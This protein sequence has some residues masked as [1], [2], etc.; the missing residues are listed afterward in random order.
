MQDDFGLGTDT[1]AA[2]GLEG[3]EWSTGVGEPSIMDLSTTFGSVTEEPSA[4]PARPVDPWEVEGGA[5]ADDAEV[6]RLPTEV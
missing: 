1:D 5:A 4:D 2:Y 3:E 6:S